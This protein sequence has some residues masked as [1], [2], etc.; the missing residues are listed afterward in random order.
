MAQNRCLPFR[1][2]SALPYQGVEQQLEGAVGLGAALG[3]EADEDYAAFSAPSL[4]RKILVIVESFISDCAPRRVTAITMPRVETLR[5]GSREAGWRLRTS[6]L[7][8]GG[9]S[10]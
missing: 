3:A 9:D 4:F 1:A 8:L 6:G 10:R 2:V 5:K 7:S